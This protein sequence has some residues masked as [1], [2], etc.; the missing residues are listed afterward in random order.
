MRSR[1]LP[2]KG[3]SG[4]DKAPRPPHNGKILN[5][6]RLDTVTTARY[7]GGTPYERP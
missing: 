5:G 2:H 6:Q 7:N 1:G 3:M 4:L